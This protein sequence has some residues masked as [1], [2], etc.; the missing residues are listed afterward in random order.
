[1]LMCF[2]PVSPCTHLSLI[3]LT[4]AVTAWKQEVDHVYK[5]SFD[6][7]FGFMHTAAKEQE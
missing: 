6:I 4:C 3:L 2:S 7:F 1:M 5:T